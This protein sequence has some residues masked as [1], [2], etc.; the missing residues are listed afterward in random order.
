MLIS[1]VLSYLT[2]VLK[3]CKLE[4][5]YPDFICEGRAIGSPFLLASLLVFCLVLPFNKKR[6]G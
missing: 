1:M 3:S 4:H 6:S 2:W 5:F